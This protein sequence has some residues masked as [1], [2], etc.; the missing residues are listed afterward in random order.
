MNTNKER[1]KKCRKWL[2]VTSA[3]AMLLRKINKAVVDTQ[4]N[5]PAT[6]M[7]QWIIHIAKESMQ[8][9]KK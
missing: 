1:R 8:R 4:F 9:A 5:P 6:I 2:N 7:M 3:N